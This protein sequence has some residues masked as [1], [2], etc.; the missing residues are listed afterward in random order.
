[1][2][3]KKFHAILALLVGMSMLLAACGPE[4]A[5]NTAV[6]QPTATTAAP[7]ADATATTAAPADATATTAM[8]EPTATTGAA[9]PSGKVFSWRAFSE[10]ASMDPAL[11]EETLSVDISQNIYD[12]LTMFDPISQELKPDIAERWES[13]ADG[14]AFTFYL[15]KDAKFSNGDPITAEDFVYSYV[16]AI[17]NPEAPYVDIVMNDIKG[18][19][20]VRAAAVST[21]T[22][23]TKPTSVPGIEAVDAN[24]LKITLNEPNGYFLSQTALWTY[25]VVNKKVVETG[26]EWFTKPGAGAGAYMLTEWKHNESMTLKPNPNFWDS[27]R[28]PNVDVFI[29]IIKETSTAQAQ[30]ERGELSVI[31]QPDPNDIKRLEADAG[32]KSQV[33]SVPNPRAVWIGLNVMKAPFGPQ[34]DEKAFKLRQAI[35]MAINREELIELAI[36]GTGVPLTNLMPEGEPGYKKFDAYAFDP[37][38]A[39]EL[40]AE[41]GYPN[42][43][44]LDLTYTY[45]QRE[46]EQRVAEQIQAQLKENLGLDVKVEGIDWAIML[47]ERQDHKYTMFYGSWGHDFPDPQNWFFPLFHSNQIKGVGTGQGNDPGWKNEEYDRLV[48]EANKLADPAKREDRFKLYQQAEEILLKDAPLVPLYQ[49]LRYWFV[50]TTKWS[51]YGTGGVGPYPFYMVKPL[52]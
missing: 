6:P 9:T 3:R 43:Q 38:K 32:M 37:A 49:P 22:T 17:T 42:G 25:Y 8:A 48:E 26:G 40:M 51:G 2:I 4:A 44:G 35:S 29:P 21:D 50:D 41:A 20:E 39:K 27:T 10:P 18:Y 30:Y 33:F 14:T 11:I 31:D 36:Q 52:Q 24:T 19:A 15:R 7:V 23:V 47:G 28:K 13:S 5:T 16:R 1:M 12:G 45:R 46:V 34:G